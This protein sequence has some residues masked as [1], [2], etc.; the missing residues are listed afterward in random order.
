MS[1]SGTSIKLRSLSGNRNRAVRRRGA[2]RIVHV[3][4]GKQFKDGILVTENAA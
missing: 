1:V 3:I 2:H 4:E